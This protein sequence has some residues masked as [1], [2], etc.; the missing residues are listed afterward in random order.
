MRADGVVLVAADATG[1]PVTDSTTTWLEGEEVVRGTGRRQQRQPLPAGCCDDAEV[2]GV[3]VDMDPDVLVAGADGAWLWD[4][5]EGREG[6]VAP[7]PDTDEWVWPVGGLRGRLVATG[8]GSEVLVEHPGGRWGW[9]YVGGPRDPGS[10]APVRYREQERVTAERVWLTLPA[11]VAVEPGGRLVVLRTRVRYDGV[12]HAWRAPTG[13]SAELELPAGLRVHGVVGE[14]R[15]TVLVDAT[16]DA[17][18][19]AWVRCHVRTLSCEVAAGLGPDD[20]VPTR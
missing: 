10:D 20:V 4:T 5:Y 8:S 7:P 18:R 2:V 15:T 14:E 17:G 12:G 3:D 16:D 13:Q 11:V 19:R 9:G 6:S 1:P